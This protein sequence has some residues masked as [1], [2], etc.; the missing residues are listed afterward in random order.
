MKG[1]FLLCR[2]VFLAIAGWLVFS[3][4]SKEVIDRK[5]LNSSQH[6]GVAK[7][8]LDKEDYLRAINEFKIVLRRY[9]DSQVGDQTLFGLAQ[10]YYFNKDYTDAVYELRRF[11][12]DYPK[13]PLMEDAQYYLSLCFLKQS[14]IAVLD[15]E[16]TKLAIDE[17]KNYLHEYPRGKYRRVAVILGHPQPDN[18]CLQNDQ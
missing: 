12:R 6:Y 13:S 17:L 4:S 8:L 15:Q 10:A 5:G 9:P 3:C 16:E 14:R 11:M 18:A 7:E 1:Y 2:L